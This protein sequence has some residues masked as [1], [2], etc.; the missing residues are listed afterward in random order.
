MLDYKAIIPPID[1]A[2]A[3]AD[4]PDGMTLRRVGVF[5]GAEV[6]GVDLT[7]PIDAEI[8]AFLT[9]AHA[10][11]GVLVLP[12]Q[13]ISGEDLMRFGRCFG[14]LSVHPFSLS[15]QENPELIVYDNHEENPPTTTDIWHSDETFRECHFK[16]HPAGWPHLH[17][18]RWR[19]FLGRACN[20]R[21]C[22]T[23]RR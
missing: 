14:E 19:H 18:D 17:A 8:V 21:V 5:L 9:R 11:H 7:R 10:E 22:R 16:S 4:A 23:Q 12:D 13:K 20:G 6:R 3:C 2:K 1:Q 15:T